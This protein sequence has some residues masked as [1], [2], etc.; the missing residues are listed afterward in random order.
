LFQPLYEK[1]VLAAQ[2]S[3][4]STTENDD[5]TRAQLRARQHTVLSAP[6]SARIVTLQVEEGASVQQGDLLFTLECAE[7]H[8]GLAIGKAR[9]GAAGARL[10]AALRLKTLDSGSE[11]DVAL[12]RAEL[13][14]VH[15]EMNRFLAI[16]VKCDVKAPFTG[17]I[18][19]RMVMPYQYVAEGEPVLEIVGTKDL[20]VE[21]VV[22][23]AWLSWLQL[24]TNFSFAVDATNQQATGYVHQ[25]GAKVDPVSQT[26]RVIGRLD[27]SA[28][29]LLPGMSGSVVFDH[30]SHKPY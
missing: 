3:N 26:L 25:L 24:K 14:A 7:H 9:E 8:A 6:L 28:D 12:A 23:A 21:M 5:K 4:I 11:L 10:D 1:V 18:A 20:E 15:A 16:L 27:C 19:T 13:A 2:V 29:H 22:P 17:R 30:D